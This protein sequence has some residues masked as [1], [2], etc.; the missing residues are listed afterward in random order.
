MKKYSYVYRITCLHPETPP[1]YYY[2]MRTS[3]VVP[4][5]DNHWSS[6]KTVKEAIK[7]KGLQ[8]FRKKL[9]AVYS[10]KTQALAYE[11]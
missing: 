7:K 3:N 8:Y 4:D 10:T 11:V 9:I 6:S 2:G 1:E 5:Q